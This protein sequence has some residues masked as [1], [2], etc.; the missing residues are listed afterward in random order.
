L[1][2]CLFNT[3]DTTHFAR[4]GVDDH[5]HDWEWPF[6]TEAAAGGACGGGV[7]EL[8]ECPFGNRGSNAVGMSTANSLLNS[9]CAPSE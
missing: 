5:K 4:F 3:A 9:I 8:L 6:N 1:F 7:G 2:V